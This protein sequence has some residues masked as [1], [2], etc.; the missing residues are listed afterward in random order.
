MHYCFAKPQAKES[1]TLMEDS[2]FVYSEIQPL[3]LFVYFDSTTR[4]TLQFRVLIFDMIRFE[5][6]PWSLRRQQ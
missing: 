4:M 6:K 5:A 2:C 3:S 1:V